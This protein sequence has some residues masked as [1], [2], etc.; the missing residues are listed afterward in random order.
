MSL[1]KGKQ[2]SWV[3]EYEAWE[4]GQPRRMCVGFGRMFIL[5]LH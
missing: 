3:K 5:S 2:Q 4:V 1:G